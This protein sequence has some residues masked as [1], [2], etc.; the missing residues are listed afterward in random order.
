MIY[1]IQSSSHHPQKTFIYKINNVPSYIISYHIFFSDFSSFFSS[2]GGLLCSCCKIAS[3][4]FFSRAYY[5]AH[6]S[7]VD[8]NYA[9]RLQWC[10]QLLNVIIMRNWISTVFAI[11]NSRINRFIEVTVFVRIGITYMEL[12]N[13]KNNKSTMG[14]VNRRSE[15]YFCSHSQTVAN[16]PSSPPSQINWM[17]YN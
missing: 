11:T 2:L 1:P 16:K 13:N 9:K 10:K 5:E 4:P 14:A 3:K 12:N 17:C 15:R 8:V 7:Q 6:V